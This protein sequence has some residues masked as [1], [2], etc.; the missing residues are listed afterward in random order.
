MFNGTLVVIQ[1]TPFCNIDCDYCYLPDRSSTERMSSEVLRAIFRRSFESKRT[2]NPLTFLWHVGEPLAAPLASYEEA[3]ALAEIE[4]RPFKREYGLA[5]QTN[6]TLVNRN[7]VELFRRHSVRLGVS[8]DG[9][10]FVHDFQRKDRLGGGTHA[11]V[12]RG[13][14][15]LRA[16]DI[17]FSVICVLSDHSLDYPDEIFEFFEGQDIV[18]VAFNAESTL[19]VHDFSTVH[20]FSRVER[21][22][23]RFLQRVDQ[24]RLRFNIRE[25]SDAYRAIRNRRGVSSEHGG[26]NSANIPFDLITVDRTGSYSTFC[27]ELRGSH[28]PRYSDFVMGN[29]VCDPFDAMVDNSVFQLVH[30]EIE[31]GVEACRSQCPY[32]FA[33]FGGSP[34]SKFFEAARLDIAEN[35]HCRHQKQAIVSALMKHIALK[36]KDLPPGDVDG[37]MDH[38]QPGTTI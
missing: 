13:I 33:C 10:A 15:H 34:S 3:F 20:S 11:R 30:R 6:G 4:N 14:D 25:I 19:G 21:F 26:R 35:D 8:L 16:A 29:V 27:P 38:A 5:I 36:A 9:P 31:R 17:P 2:T 22:F 1:G 18:N 32:W 24:S 12:M 28:A 37:S 23:R 7:W